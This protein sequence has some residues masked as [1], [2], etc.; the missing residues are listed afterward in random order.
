MAD[1][2]S[3]SERE[4]ERKN[5]P[6]R[7]EVD[8]PG[9]RKRNGRVSR[10]SIRNACVQ[11]CSVDP[12]QKRNGHQGRE[13]HCKSS[14]RVLPWDKTQD[15]GSA[16]ADDTPLNQR[17]EQSKRQDFCH[18]VEA[19]AHRCRYLALSSNSRTRASSSA[20]M[21]LSSRMFSS[22]RSWEFPKN[23]LTRC[24]TSKRVASSRSILDI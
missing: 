5:P 7:Q 2:P 14:G 12:W 6:R 17:V 4:P 22:R 13:P 24:R 10:G 16:E 3:Y 19:N 23:R 20:S 15:H 18:C 1:R 9:F 8:C 21:L 11:P